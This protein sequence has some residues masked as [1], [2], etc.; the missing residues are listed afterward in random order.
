MVRFNIW[1]KVRFSRLDGDYTVGEICYQLWE[2]LGRPVEMRPSLDREGND[3][4]IKFGRLNLEDG[5]TD[6]L[7]DETYFLGREYEDG[8]ALLHKV[9]L[10]E[11]P[12]TGKEI[13]EVDYIFNEDLNKRDCLKWRFKRG[14]NKLRQE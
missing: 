14:L 8:R 5:N 9:R 3:K 7:L 4:W 6:W 13:F 10:Q 11:R 1:R 2:L 12:F